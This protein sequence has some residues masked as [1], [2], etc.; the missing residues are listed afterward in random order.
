[1]FYCP[2]FSRMPDHPDPYRLVYFH[3]G[4]DLLCRPRMCGG[5]SALGLELQPRQVPG[6]PDTRQPQH[7]ASH[8]TLRV[9]APRPALRPG[10]NTSTGHLPASVLPAQ[11]DP[12]PRA[13]HVLHPGPRAQRLHPG[14]GGRR[15]VQA[16]LQAHHGHPAVLVNAGPAHLAGGCHAAAG[17]PLDSTG[18]MPSVCFGNGGVR[19]RSPWG[20]TVR[21]EGLVLGQ[22]G[23]QG[24]L[25]TA[26]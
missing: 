22:D 9:C 21:V 1:M 17:L 8:F 7:T 12:A 14:L 5:L 23:D 16:R 2:V 4:L 10:G 19:Q 6:G 11:N 25:S 26:L 18:K 24:K 3:S 20:G 13:H 15:S